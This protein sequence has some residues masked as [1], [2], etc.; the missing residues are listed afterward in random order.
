[1]VLLIIS[2]CELMSQMLTRMG[3][4]ISKKQER[5]LNTAIIIYFMHL[6]ASGHHNLKSFILDRLSKELL[7]VTLVCSLREHLEKQTVPLLKLALITRL[8]SFFN[9]TSEALIM[10]IILVGS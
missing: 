8:S 10:S 2:L 3:E 5:I 1:M 9:Q 4:D 6:G 7:V